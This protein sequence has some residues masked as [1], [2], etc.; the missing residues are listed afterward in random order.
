MQKHGNLQGDIGIDDRE[1]LGLVP[2]H[3]F[4]LGCKLLD[5]LEHAMIEPHWSGND[6]SDEYQGGKVVIDARCGGVACPTKGYLGIDA[7][8][9][10]LWVEGLL[11]GFVPFGSE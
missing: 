9:S 7:G 5:F 8:K 3:V 10:F 2:V 4:W 1:R 6:G 11:A